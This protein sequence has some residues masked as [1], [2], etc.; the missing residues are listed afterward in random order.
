[1]HF[2]LPALRFRP[3][4]PLTCRSL[5]HR[6]EA[7]RLRASGASKPSMIS[8]S[9]SS[10]DVSEA[11]LHVD[12]VLQRI[13]LAGIGCP[14]IVL[15][16]ELAG[17]LGDLFCNGHKGARFLFRVDHVVRHMEDAL[18]E[19]ELVTAFGGQVLHLHAELFAELPDIFVVGIDELSAELAEHALV[20][21]RIG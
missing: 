9:L 4:R 17:I 2:S 20:E 5:D 1:M 16:G 18:E 13:Q 7:L 8:P 3:S 11:L 21:N 12:L 6:I 10:S 15:V 14:I 19:V